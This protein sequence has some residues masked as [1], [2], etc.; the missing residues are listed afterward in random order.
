MYR[1]NGK[2]LQTYL[3]IQSFSYT[4]TASAAATSNS[5]STSTKHGPF[6]S[7]ED[8]KLADLAWKRL[9]LELEPIGEEDL[10]RVKAL[11]YD[12]GLKVVVGSAG[13]QDGDARIQV[14]NILVGLHV[15]PTPTMKDLAQILN[16]DDL[17]ELNPLKFYVVRNEQTGTRTKPL[18][19]TSSAPAALT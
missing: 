2:Q 14:G 18:S 12:G 7:L 16:R 15:W 19:A 4:A 1:P 10:K 13:I 5:D 3:P 8:Q 6:P 11:G 9:S 17:A